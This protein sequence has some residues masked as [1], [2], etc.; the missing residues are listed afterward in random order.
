MG[1]NP[2]ALAK[3]STVSCSRAAASCSS[4]FSSQ[5]RPACAINTTQTNRQILDIFYFCQPTISLCRRPGRYSGS[6]RLIY[7]RWPYSST[8]PRG[9]RRSMFN[10]WCNRRSSTRMPESGLVISSPPLNSNADP[11]SRKRPIPIKSSALHFS[12]IVY[13]QF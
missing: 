2:Y 6:Y 1:A 13:S 8:T 11:T 3:Y 9:S 7:S 12:A 4:W 10:H 5:A